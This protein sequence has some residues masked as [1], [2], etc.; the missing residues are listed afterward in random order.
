MT[1]APAQERSSNIAKG[2]LPLIKFTLTRRALQPIYLAFNIPMLSLII[3]PLI[4]LAYIVIP[5]KGKYR[6]IIAL[7]IVVFFVFLFLPSIR[8]DY[9]LSKMGAHQTGIVTNV[10]C[11]VKNN[12]YVDYNFFVENR[13]YLGS[14]RPGKGNQ[15][16]ENQ[17]IGNQVFITYLPHNENVNVPERSVEH[18]L[19]AYIFGFIFLYAFLLWVGKAQEKFRANKKIA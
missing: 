7:L 4:F 13:K 19:P 3:P 6:P 11:N 14:G 16:C 5:I 17:R 9:L 18:H 1:R 12:Q 8:R 2:P 10:N 15:R